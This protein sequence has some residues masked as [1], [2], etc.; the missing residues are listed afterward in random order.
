MTVDVIRELQ[1]DET[2]LKDFLRK[3]DDA[4]AQLRAINS[5][6]NREELAERLYLWSQELG[7]WSG[8]T[9][10]WRQ[11]PE[12]RRQFYLALADKLLAH[13]KGQ[14]AEISQKS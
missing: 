10:T 2:F 5:K 13:L 14:D 4:L 3:H 8:A 7:N 6:L 1:T 12:K 9:R 11:L